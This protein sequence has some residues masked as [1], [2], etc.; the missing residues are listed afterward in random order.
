M[1]WLLD[2]NVL[3]E[4]AKPVPDPGVVAWLRE[5]DPLDF[6]ISVLVLGEI[7]S[8]VERMPEGSRKVALRAWLDSD[9]PDQFAGRLLDVDQSVAHAWGAL[10]AGG[11]RMGRPLPVIDGLMLATA[12]VHGLTLVTRNTRDVKDRGVPVVDPWD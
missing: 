10:T 6:A 2:T 7:R 12:A 9:L 11:L 4:A 5:E 8:G 1:R 3:S